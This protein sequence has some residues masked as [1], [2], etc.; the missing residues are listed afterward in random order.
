MLYIC[1]HF[2]IFFRF[3][4]LYQEKSGNPGWASF[5]AIFSHTHLVT[6]LAMVYFP[7]VGRPTGVNVVVFEYFLKK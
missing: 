6:L 5:W 3:G 2:G 4:M 1:G 7:L